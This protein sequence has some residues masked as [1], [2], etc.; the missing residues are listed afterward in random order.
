MSDK[1]VYV[2][3]DAVKLLLTLKVAKEKDV[4]VDEKAL[5]S[6]IYLLKAKDIIPFGYTFRFEPLPYSEDM[7]NEFD[8]LTR[9]GLIS[10]FPSGS[11]AITFSGE[12]LLKATKGLKDIYRNIKNSPIEQWAKLD[13]KELFNESYKES[14]SS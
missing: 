6:Y 11:V 13:Y 10:H 1:G 14:L 3:K 5:P 4:D 7:E 9:T 2:I 8:T 12:T